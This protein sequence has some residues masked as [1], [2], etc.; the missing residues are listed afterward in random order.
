MGKFQFSGFAPV[1]QFRRATRKIESKLTTVSS[2]RKTMLYSFSCRMN[3]EPV[4]FSLDF[5][6]IFRRTAATYS[7]EVTIERARTTISNIHHPAIQL[8]TIRLEPSLS[9]HSPP[10]KQLSHFLLSLR[11]PPTSTTVKL[12]PSFWNFVSVG[13]WQK[14][15]ISRIYNL[16]HPDGCH[17]QQA[18]T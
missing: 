18:P 1:A 10:S 6:W 11:C 9:V 8:Q 16:S 13:E 12:F 17:S 5:E 14:V 7:N 15:Y 2:S 3:G 4:S